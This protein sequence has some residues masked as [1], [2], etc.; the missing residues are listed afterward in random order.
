MNKEVER[1][2]MFTAGRGSA[3]TYRAWNEAVICLSDLQRR[4]VELTCHFPMFYGGAGSGK[5]FMACLNAV[6]TASSKEDATYLVVSCLGYRGTL[7]HISQT[8]ALL[9]QLGI[10][11][12]VNK[13][14]DTVWI[15]KNR[16]MIRFA[17]SKKIAEGICW[18]RP[19]DGVGVDDFDALY[20]G[21]IDGRHNQEAFLRQIGRKVAPNARVR[22]Y[23]TPSQHKNGLDYTRWRNPNSNTAFYDYVQEETNEETV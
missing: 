14:A 20:T 22:F 23:C 6:L 10:E 3:M 18:L 19:F 9:E 16:S 1:M 13:T 15:Q 5:S 4:Y 21:P 12:K 8:V 11:H 2:P 17:E 7:R